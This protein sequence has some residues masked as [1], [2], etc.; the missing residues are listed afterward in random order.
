MIAVYSTITSYVC[1][2]VIDCFFYLFWLFVE[3]MKF[4]TIENI[5]ATLNY[6]KNPFG[7]N[8][9]SHYRTC[10]WRILP[11]CCC[12]W[13]AICLIG[14]QTI[15][16]GTPGRIIELLM[17]DYFSVYGKAD[18]MLYVGLQ[19]MLKSRKY[20]V[21]ISDNNVFSHNVKLDTTY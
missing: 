3:N 15:V 9:G 16:V 20:Y 18:Q 21:E 4:V 13:C 5:L 8:L 14:K 19:R 6:R 1:R 10:G 12:I 2:R 7:T 11:V 17:K